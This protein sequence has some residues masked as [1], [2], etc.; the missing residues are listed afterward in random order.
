MDASMHQIRIEALR[1]VRY[2]ALDV[3]IMQDS[4]QWRTSVE[5][6]VS[7]RERLCWPVSQQRA[8]RIPTVTIW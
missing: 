1:Q 7:P 3:A 6:S 2:L 5:V 4:P 8:S